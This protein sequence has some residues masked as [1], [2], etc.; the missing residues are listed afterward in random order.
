MFCINNFFGIYLIRAPHFR[1]K[2]K[3]N[4][5]GVQNNDNKFKNNRG[6]SMSQKALKPIDFSDKTR[7]TDI[8]KDLYCESEITKS[9]GQ[10]EVNLNDKTF[11]QNI[12]ILLLFTDQG[13]F[14][15]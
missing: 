9:R 11:L 12:N 2:Q 4:Y 5:H 14:K 3:R 13:V 15:N 6:S 7:L 1:E 8:I 10:K